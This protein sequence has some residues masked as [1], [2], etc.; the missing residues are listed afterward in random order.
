[1]RLELS[2]RVG[3]DPSRMAVVSTSMVMFQVRNDSGTS[4]MKAVVYLL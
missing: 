1:M 4:P 2:D 3:V